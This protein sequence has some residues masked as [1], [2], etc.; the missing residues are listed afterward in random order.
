MPSYEKA[1]AGYDGAHMGPLSWPAGEIP[2]P[3]TIPKRETG[4]NRVSPVGAPRKACWSP[5]CRDW[6][7]SDVAACDSLAA[8]AVAGVDGP[9]LRGLRPRARAPDECASRSAYC[10]ANCGSAWCIVACVAADRE[11]RVPSRDRTSGGYHRGTRSQLAGT[12]DLVLKM[13]PCGVRTQ[14]KPAQCCG[15]AGL[16]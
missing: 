11:P 3:K 13:T 12:R 15:Y 9:F 6:S 14:R 4:P 8:C 7:I 10:I 1:D 2:Q 16:P 5:C